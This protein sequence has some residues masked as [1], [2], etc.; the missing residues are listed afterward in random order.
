MALRNAILAAL[1][2]GESSGYDLAKSFDIAVANFWSATAQQLYRELD[3][4]EAEGL[5]EARLIEQTRRPNKRMFSL[6]E[7][8]RATL[9]DF[10]ARPPKATAIRDE[11]L[12]QVEAME[13]GDFAAV[14]SNL[15]AKRTASEGKLRRYEQSRK[16]LLDGRTERQYL[17]DTQRL[18]HYLTLARG[19][20]FEEENIRWCAYV[21]GVL[22]PRDG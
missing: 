3:K 17:K 14:R 11:L 12:V 15:E 7:A 6:T 21:L 2:D 8:G 19:I 1:A 22:G 20:A 16:E 9:H 10:I 13:T 18:G 4:L 5:V